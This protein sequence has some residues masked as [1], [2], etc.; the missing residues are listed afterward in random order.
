MVFNYRSEV[1]FCGFHGSQYS[2]IYSWSKNNGVNYFNRNVK[3]LS[4]GKIETEIEN[5]ENV[6][7][8]TIY[9]S[10]SPVAASQIVSC[11]ASNDAPVQTRHG[12]PCETTSQ[13]WVLVAL[14]ANKTGRIYSSSY[15]MHA[16]C[17]IS[18]LWRNS[19]TK[20]QRC[21]CTLNIPSIVHASICV[22]AKFPF[23]Q[24]G[25]K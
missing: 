6:P 23:F 14:I 3:V 5:G 10:I 22:M 20:K 17:K 8:Q 18:N 12:W 7:H 1:K 4:I 15:F 25:N 19:T 24:S 11:A 2:W 9:V 13:V 21:Y 16:E